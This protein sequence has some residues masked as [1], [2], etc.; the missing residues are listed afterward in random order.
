LFIAS[1]D[2]KKKSPHK[3]DILSISNLRQKILE[4]NNTR[5][6]LKNRDDI[7]YKVLRTTRRDKVS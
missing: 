3:H 2:E 4:Q 6:K 7:V 1:S 5:L